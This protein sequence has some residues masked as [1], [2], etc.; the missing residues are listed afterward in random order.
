MP[1]GANRARWRLA[2]GAAAF[3]GTAVRLWRVD[4]KQSHVQRAAADRNDDGVAI[5]HAHDPA[6]QWVARAMPTLGGRRSRRAR[7]PPP[8]RATRRVGRWTDTA[9]GARPERRD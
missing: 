6:L 7:P 4:A 8:R 1:A 5:H 2:A 3:D 9:C